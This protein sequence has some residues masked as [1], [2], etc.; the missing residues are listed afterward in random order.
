MLT[1]INY[2]IAEY[3]FQYFFGSEYA[4]SRAFRH[5]EKLTQL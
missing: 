4:F 5:I 2:K 3:E 1:K